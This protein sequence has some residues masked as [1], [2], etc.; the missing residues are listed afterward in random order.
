MLT[1]DWLVLIFAANFVISFEVHDFIARHHARRVA[2]RACSH[3]EHSSS[4]SR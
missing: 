3:P 4:A 2:L 1:I